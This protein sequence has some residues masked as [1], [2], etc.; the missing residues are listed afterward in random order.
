MACSFFSL[1]ILTVALFGFSQNVS[2]QQSESLLLL[3]G[4]TCNRWHIAWPEI[5]TL[6]GKI[7][8]WKKCSPGV[9]RKEV[10]GGGLW[11]HSAKLLV[12]PNYKFPKI[13][14]RTSVIWCYCYLLVLG[15]SPSQEKQTICDTT[16]NC[17]EARNLRETSH[18]KMK[19]GKDFVTTRQYFLSNMV[20]FLTVCGFIVKKF[21]GETKILFDLSNRVKRSFLLNSNTFA[22]VSKN[23]F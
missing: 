1:A 22:T 3:Y 20:T 15:F 23:S 17:I 21:E 18:C 19:L 6:W 10:V 11:V 5:E 4:T 9:W 14:G 16:F 2:Q 12:N 8:P 7:E 13:K